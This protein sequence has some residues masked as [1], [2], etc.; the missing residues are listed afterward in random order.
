MRTYLNGLYV[1][2]YPSGH[3]DV[4]TVLVR[5]LAAL[6]GEWTARVKAVVAAS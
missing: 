6:T 1:V 4:T 5:R 3:P 2:D